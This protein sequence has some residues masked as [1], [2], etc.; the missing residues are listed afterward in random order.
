MKNGGSTSSRPSAASLIEIDRPLQ[1]DRFNLINKPLH[2]VRE[3]RRDHLKHRVTEAAD[4]QYVMPLRRLRRRVRLQVDADQLR[5][6]RLVIGQLPLIVSA[7][8]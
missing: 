1:R 4:V 3:E 6:N 8:W 5:P 2:V 7:P